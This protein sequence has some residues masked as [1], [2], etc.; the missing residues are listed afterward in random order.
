MVS[1]VPWNLQP[2]Q[3]LFGNENAMR[4]AD[5]YRKALGPNA[6]FFWPRFTRTALDAWGMCKSDAVFRL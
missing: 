6:Y 3:L 5:F 2:L 1:A 4:F